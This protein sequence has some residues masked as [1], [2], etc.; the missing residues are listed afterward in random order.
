MNLALFDLDNTLLPIDSDYAWG[1]F[2]N[3]MGWNDPVAFKAKNDQF[4]PITSRVLWIFTIMFV[5]QRRL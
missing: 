4:M 3:R 5:L 1:E 2:T